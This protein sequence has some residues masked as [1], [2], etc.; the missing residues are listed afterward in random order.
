MIQG[1]RQLTDRVYWYINHA[2]W[3]VNHLTAM[4]KPSNSNLKPAATGRDAPV[5]NRIGN[6]LKSRKAAVSTPLQGAE[7]HAA[8]GATAESFSGLYKSE[9]EMFKSLSVATKI[10]Y[11][12]PYALPVLSPEVM[13]II[14]NYREDS[15]IALKGK[16]EIMLKVHD[17]FLAA[18]KDVGESAET[19]EALSKAEERAAKA[20][21][22]ARLAKEQA[23]LAKSKH[24]LLQ[25]EFDGYKE[26]MARL[27]AQLDKQ[28]EELAELRKV[29]G[30]MTES[31]KKQQQV[32]SDL[33]LAS[34]LED[35]KM[36]ALELVSNR[37]VG[38]PPED[39]KKTGKK[40][41]LK[42]TK[43]TPNK[44]VAI[45]VDELPSAQPDSLFDEL[46]QV[47]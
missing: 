32:D 36:D 3:L 47:N 42:K 34:L 25:R 11:K 45:D 18:A 13:Q 28:E 7:V 31:Q 40:R 24:T 27:S 6:F 33:L 16:L 20:T 23:A 10:P 43:E 4:S 30:V 17:A 9:M 29:H 38:T 14:R 35:E 39:N 12:S 22:E 8:V 2:T 19:K 46:S 37:D 5:T 41:R 44:K 15:S 21:E 26:N 1:F